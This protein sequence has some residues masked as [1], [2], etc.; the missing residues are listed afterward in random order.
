LHDI[1][2]EMNKLEKDIRE[3][4]LLN[5]GAALGRFQ[6][7]YGAVADQMSYLQQIVGFMDFDQEASKKKGLAGGDLT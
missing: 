1:N 5:P 6:Q 2:G 3:D 4:Q 7:V